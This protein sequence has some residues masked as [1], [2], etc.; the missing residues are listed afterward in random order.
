V[1][2]P[3]RAPDDVHALAKRIRE[4]PD[5]FERARSLYD[6]T[7]LTC[8]PA[9]LV[10]LVIELAEDDD[11]GVRTTVIAVLCDLD[12]RGID[13]LTPMSLALRHG[14]GLP[15]TAHAMEVVES[16]KKVG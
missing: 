10:G 1:A 11:K 13:V 14:R 3:R 15:H 8:D 7:K 4:A 5:A 16:R 12:K 9:P 6:V 2:G